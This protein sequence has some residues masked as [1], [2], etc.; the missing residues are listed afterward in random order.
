MLK[1]DSATRRW[2]RGGTEMEENREGILQANADDLRA[3]E[4]FV[5]AGQYVSGAACAIAGAAKSVYGNGGESTR[6]RAV[7]GSA[8][9]QLAVTELDEGLLLTKET[10]RWVWWRWCLNRV[11]TWCRKWLR[12]R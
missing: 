5:S 1:V 10:C 3:A 11:R 9:K 7:A 4:E 2:S 6:R 12:W 8:G